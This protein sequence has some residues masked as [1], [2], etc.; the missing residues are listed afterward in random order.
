MSLLPSCF[1]GSIQD[2]QGAKRAVS[3]SLFRL[4]IPIKYQD[5]QPQTNDLICLGQE[6]TKA[7]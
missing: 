3:S 5:L 7:R 1:T 6:V 4:D 2:Y